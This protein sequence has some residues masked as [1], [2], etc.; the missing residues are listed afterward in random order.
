ML[1]AEVLSYV[2]YNDYERMVVLY[3]ISKYHYGLYKPDLVVI[4]HAYIWNW[5]TQKQLDRNV[6]YK[7]IIAKIVIVIEIFT[8]QIIIKII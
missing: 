2:S 3:I 1:K 7:S 4:L 5:I 8:L 6:S